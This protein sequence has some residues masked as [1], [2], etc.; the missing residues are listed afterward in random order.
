MAES[1]TAPTTGRRKRVKYA[2]RLIDYA[3]AYGYSDDRTIKNWVATGK[4]NGELPP[5]DSPELMADWWKRHHHNRPLPASL[6]GLGQ[7]ELAPVSAPPT[8][9]AETT[10]PAPPSPMTSGKSF[11]EQVAELRRVLDRSLA[12]LQAVTAETCPPD[13]TDR[14]AWAR[15]R[16][17]RMEIARKNYQGSF[18]VLRKAENDLVEW[19]RQHEVLVPRSEVAEEVSRIFRAIHAGVKRLLRK[20]R[21]AL[22]GLPDAAADQLWDAETRA[23]FDSLLRSQFADVC[24]PDS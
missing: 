1:E 23:C 19:E 22:H 14:E 18:D 8:A 16:S 15:G 5:L 4:D 3:R 13:V 24:N 21:P 17:A 11:P 9:P 20:V 2:R 6:C 7:L 12:E 10:Q